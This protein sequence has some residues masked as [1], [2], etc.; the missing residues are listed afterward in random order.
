MRRGWQPPILDDSSSKPF[1]SDVADADS[2]QQ[3]GYAKAVTPVMQLQPASLIIANLYC[4]SMADGADA[5]WRGNPLGVSAVVNCAEDDWLHQVKKG[6]VGSEAAVF[7]SELREAF[8][9]LAEA[10]EGAAHYGTV[11]GMEYMG[12]SAKDAVHHAASD[13]QVTGD[14]KDKVADHFPASLAFVQK[15]LGRGEKVLIHCLRGENRSAAVCAAFLMMQ[16]GLPCEEAI[17]LLRNKRGDNALSNQGFVEE[18]RRL[19]LASP[20]KTVASSSEA[21]QWSPSIESA[22]P[23]KTVSTSDGADSVGWPPSPVKPVQ[24]EEVCASQT[25]EASQ[26][27]IACE[28]L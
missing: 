27:S 3:D 23:M 9:R 22:S 20:A 15:H 19:P 21:T 12:F 16:R 28:I 4:G 5:L 10:P 26:R 2:D 6:R 18:L 25:S 14:S 1:N 17:E 7:C 24:H 11:M 13:R 8:D